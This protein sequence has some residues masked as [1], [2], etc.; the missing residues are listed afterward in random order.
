MLL[1]AGVSIGYQLVAKKQG[2]SDIAC[3]RGEQPA[4]T[5]LLTVSRGIQSPIS[6]GESRRLIRVEAGHSDIDEAPGIDTEF[7]VSAGC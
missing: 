2:A 1:V 5:S 7:E 4:G 3:Q 6:A